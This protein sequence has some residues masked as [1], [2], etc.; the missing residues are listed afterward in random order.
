MK[1]SSEL[2]QH[3]LKFFQKKGHHVCP[4]ST[5][6]P[7]SDPS[8]LFTNAGMVPFKD[9]F[10]GKQALPY[11]RAVSAQR[12]VR[13]GGKHNDLENVGYTARHHTFFEMLGNFS[14]GDYF[15]KEAIAWSWEFLTQELDLPVDRLWITVFETDDEAARIWH[16]DIGIPKERIIRSGEKDN[17][18]SMGDTGPCGPC[19]EIFYDH[20]DSIPGGPPGSAESD[21]DRFVE[22]WNLV[23]MQYNRD[24]SGVLSPLPSPCVDTGMGLERLAAV[25]QGVHN[26]F[27]T[28][29]FVPLIQKARCFLPH[30][31]IPLPHEWISLRVLA[32]HI[33]S[34][35]F[36]I[37]DGVLPASLGRGYVLR[38]M[39]R[40]AL[41][42]GH[43][44]GIE[45]PFFG[46]LLEP[47]I[48]VMGGAY[49]DLLAKQ[50]HIRD[51]ILQEETQFARTLSQGMRLLEQ[52]LRQISGAVF[53]GELAFKLYDTYG[54]PL[55]LTQDIARE[56]NL[57]V[58]VQAFEA[59]MSVQKEKSHEHQRFH[60]VAGL[61]WT[62]QFPMT[63]F[64]GYETLCSAA[65]ILGFQA[66]ELCQVVLDR[67]PCYAESGGQIGDT[68]IIR[69]EDGS[70]EGQ[71]EDTQKNQGV[72]IH[73]VRVTRGQPHV[74]QAVQVEVD[75]G[76]RGAIARHHSATH[77]L[78]AAL[79]AKF[80]DSVQQR[81]S[82]V[83]P[84]R[85]RFDFAFHRGLTREEIQDITQVVQSQIL[86]NTPVG[87]K[88]MGQ[89]EAK[90]LGAMAL[91]DEKY[92]DQ[93]RVLFMGEDFSIELCGGTHVSRTGDI[94]PFWIL[95]E[96]SV[97]SGVRR[98]EAVA[99]LPA[100]QEHVLR[101]ERWLEMA[102]ILKTSPKQLPEKMTALLTKI[103][104]LEQQ[105]AHKERGNLS[106]QIQ[107]WVSQA[108]LLV[109]GERKICLICQQIEA[110]EPAKVRELIDRI[111][112]RVDDAVMV[113]ASVISN[114]K[115]ALYIGVTSDLS[116][117][118]SAG[119]LI[120]SLS[121]PL[122]GRGGGRA[123]FA[124]AG[125]SFPEK[126]PQVL[127]QV[128]VWIE[129]EVKKL[130]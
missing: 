77:L 80:G 29:L 117:V 14:F 109:V 75:A 10:L 60:S 21:G 67:T 13:A 27:D 86:N 59:C 50:E 45:G 65:R 107:Q 91:F 16:E 54:F 32:D 53:P 11:T 51:V 20:G 119:R 35:A 84:D 1:T 121:E 90:A 114:E 68:A 85:L 47:L 3:F 72:F 123:D 2:R 71:I 4:S 41:R 73:A 30:Q 49:P 17:F 102:Q 15:K 66:G 40:R 22:I 36:L 78:H 105:L 61:D 129:Y 125:G 64:E 98:I 70:F 97:S 48:G 76:R 128:P 5:L 74:G 110:T 24:A 23:F 108:Q 44:L 62:G 83:G 56:Q 81:G 6:I 79:R 94:G 37:L 19:S 9:V 39:M 127:A 12:C 101:E 38:R 82:A 112:D 69:A 87:I 7:A 89:N 104:S 118:C 57:T 99:G 126:L 18:W 34:T 106:E 43:R 55:D 25:M 116:Q 124:Q 103:K 92:G 88:N 111:K 31:Q 93:V 26:N 113:F 8:L 33:R 120:Q 58:D 95:Q 130:G 63:Q 52:E 96:S 115:V 100:L 28:D 42:H 122:G 46:A